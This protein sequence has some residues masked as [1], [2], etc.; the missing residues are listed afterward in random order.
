MNKMHY[1]ATTLGNHEF[2]L[3]LDTLAQNLS[4]ANFDV[5]MF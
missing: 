4:L 3:G 1:T 2:D 5:I